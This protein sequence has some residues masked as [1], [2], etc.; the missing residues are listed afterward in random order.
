[1]CLYPT[2]IK[3]PKYK[4]NRKNGGNIPPVTDERVKYVPIGCQEC[5]ECRKQKA[6]EWQTRMLEDLKDHTNGKFITL[7]FSNEELQELVKENKELQNLS[8]YILDN[9]IAVRA[10]RLFLERWRKEY[11][12]S[13]RHWFVTELGHKGTEN[14]HLHGIVWTNK[15]MDEIRAK[16][17]YGYM[18]P[19]PGSKEKNYVNAKTVNYIIKYVTKV[20]E[21]HR[22]YKSQIMTSPG[23]GGNYTKRSDWKFSIDF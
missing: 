16:W 17:K 21:D 4:A 11:K 15:T 20:D 19:R 18:W 8:G 5:I 7:T 1:M 2:L 10:V 6:R 22:Y 9:A 23:I 3:N 13:L 12:K 14:I